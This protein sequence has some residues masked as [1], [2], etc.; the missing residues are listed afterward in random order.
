MTFTG[1]LL[2][3]QVEAV[4]QMTE[5]GQMLVAYDLGLGKTVLTIAAIETLMDDGIVRSPGLVICLSSLKFQWKDQ[6][7]KFTGSTSQSVVIDGTPKQ[8]SELYAQV[9]QGGFDYVIMNYETVVKDWNYVKNLSRGFIVIDEATAIKSFRAKRSKHVKML[10]KNVDIKFALTGTPIE[11]GK[12]EELFSIMEFVDPRVLGR[13]DLFD[14]AFIVRSPYGYA[15]RYKNLPV[16]HRK[17]APA[18]IRKTQQ[19]PDVKPFLPDTIYAE[20]IRTRFDIQG[21]RLYEAI[22]SHLED[23]LEEMTNLFPTRD[24]LSWSGPVD[25]EFNEIRGRIMGKVTALR[26]LCNHPDLIRK[27][28]AE[29]SALNGTGSQYAARLLEE[30]YLDKATKTPKLDA[31]VQ[32]A[33]DFLDTDPDNKLVIFSTFVYMT[34]LIAKRLTSYGAVTYTGHLNAK[35]KEAAKTLFQTDPATRVLVSSDAGGYGVDLPQ[36]NCLINYDL[37]WSAGTAKQRNGRIQRASSTWKS[38]VVQDMLMFNSLEE[39]QHD[40]LIR[41]AL[42]LS[43]IIDNHETEDGEIYM[44]A[45]TL[46][47]FL[48]THTV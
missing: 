2:P 46:T 40:M 7:D 44:T 23:D 37:P 16:L 27:S 18:M 6:I 8:R 1:T 32:Y 47:E 3:Y 29:F 13:F 33:Q 25:D 38:V 22:V 5:R 15:E 20:P 10:A 35:Q 21:K 14:E 26:M 12:P 31:V 24:L 4:E 19:D 45:T 34:D 42:V 11:N 30:G 48:R 43:S 9:R 17:I 39:R 36:A 28:G 41:K